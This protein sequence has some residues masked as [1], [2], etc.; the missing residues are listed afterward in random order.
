MVLSMDSDEL[1]DIPQPNIHAFVS[2]IPGNGNMPLERDVQHTGMQS[3]LGT[4]DR[5]PPVVRDACE[6]IKSANSIS[7][8]V[9]IAHNFALAYIKPEMQFGGKLGQERLVSFVELANDPVGDCDDYA[10]FTA[11]LLVYGGVD[12]QDI[13]VLDGMMRYEVSGIGNLEAGHEFLVVRDHDRNKDSYI[14]VDNNLADTPEID[15]AHPTVRARL[16]TNGINIP[17]LPGDA[18]ETTADIV[19]ISNCVDARGTTYVNEEAQNKLANTMKEFVQ[20]LEKV[21]SPTPLAVE[22]K[23]LAE[24]SSST[25]FLP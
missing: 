8:K 14:L 20:K 12:P 17:Q 16:F 22:G 10:K 18:P 3:Q 23:R 24:N 25:K 11:G 15:P 21:I 5:L 13:F 4:W 2:K 9:A 1:L 6:E 7:E 19:Y